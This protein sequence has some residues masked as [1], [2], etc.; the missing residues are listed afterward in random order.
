MKKNTKHILAGVLLCT[1]L[2]TPIVL[3]LGNSAN[4]A[5]KSQITLKKAKKIALKHAGYKSSEVTF[6]KAKLDHDDGNS[7]YD[8]EFYNGSKEYDYEIDAKTGKILEY[9]YEIEENYTGKKS[10]NLITEK[11]AQTIALNHAKLKESEIDY[12]KVK[13]DDDDGKTVYEV[14]FYKG[15]LEYNYEINAKTGDILEW[16]KEFDD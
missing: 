3:S 14:E 6:S 11:K 15:N 10:T 13:L 7:V 9:D 5:A 8:I 12:I 2:C 16:D 1:T 4:I